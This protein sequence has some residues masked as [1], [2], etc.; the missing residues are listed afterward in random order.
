MYKDGR[1][2]LNHILSKSFGVLSD[3]ANN[4]KYKTRSLTKLR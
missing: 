4:Q 3:I 1:D 2:I